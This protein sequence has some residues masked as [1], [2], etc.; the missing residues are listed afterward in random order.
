MNLKIGA[1]IKQLRTEKHITQETLAGSLGVSPQAIS[2]WEQ[3]NGY[4]DI[5]LLPTLADV[6][7]VSTDE[8]LGYKLSEREQ[9]LA[10]IKA[11]I[12]RLSEVGT[13]EECL[14]FARNAVSRYPFDWQ[15]KENLAVCLYLVWEEQRDPAM[16]AEIEG[17]C[18]AIIDGCHDEDTRYDAIYT[19]NRLYHGTKQPEKALEAVKLLTPL[20]YCREFA[21]SQGVGDSN[22]EVY[23]QDEIDKLTDCLGVAIRGYVLAEDLPNDPE[24]WDKKIEMLRVANQLYNM[25]YGD[26]LMFHHNRVAFNHWIISTYEI[27]QGKQDAALDSLERMCAHTVAYD[28]SYANDHGKYFTSMFTNKLI[29]PEPSKDFHE[30]TEHTQAYYMLERMQHERYDAVREHRRF[31]AII[32]VLQK[33]AK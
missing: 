15:I 16:M 20:K 17:L 6:F 30:L 13:I 12:H 27:A 5:E 3:G 10:D 2:R 14:A 1:I 28:Q 7:S 9:E 19:L 26:D 18:T 11:E 32:A 8:L 4:P 33:T 21:L 25:I 31:A 29:Y 24:T 23:I 22:T